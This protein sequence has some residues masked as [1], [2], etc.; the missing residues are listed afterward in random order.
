MEYLCLAGEHVNEVFKEYI[1]PLPYNHRRI[2]AGW[3]QVPMREIQIS[4]FFAYY[5]NVLEL[6]AA[7]PGTLVHYRN[8]LIYAFVDL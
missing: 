7:S 5:V 8:R 6:P 3:M 1:V 4:G 2:N